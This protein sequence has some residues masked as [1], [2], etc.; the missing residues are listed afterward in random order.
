MCQ[1]QRHD[2]IAMSGLTSCGV[3]D[4]TKL[5][6]WLSVAF[7]AV[8]ICV[9]CYPSA[10]QC[11]S[12]MFSAFTMWWAPCTNKVCS[13]LVFCAM[14]SCHLRW[15]VDGCGCLG[16]C[17]WCL[18]CVDCHCSLPTKS[19]HYRKQ[20]QRDRQNSAFNPTA[21]QATGLPGI[22]CCFLKLCWSMYTWN[23]GAMQSSDYIGYC[24]WVTMAFI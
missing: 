22:K 18:W 23:C 15:P 2:D 8:L 19:N 6:A 3:A 24:N 5:R 21:F 11:M 4:P 14:V 13:K 12:V 16:L 1:P 17:I 10:S 20:T 7:R 9:L